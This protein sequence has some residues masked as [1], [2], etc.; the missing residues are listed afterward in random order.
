MSRTKPVFQY[1]KQGDFICS[2]QSLKEASIST[3]INIKTISGCVRGRTHVGM[4]FIW[5]FYFTEDKTK[6]VHE[7]KVKRNIVSIYN[8]KGILIKTFPSQKELSN[9]LNVADYSITHSKK[10][11]QKCKGFYVADGENSTFDIPK[12]IKNTYTFPKCNLNSIPKFKST[13]LLEDG[14]FYL[15]RHIRPDKNE[16]FYIGIGTK[17]S[18]HCGSYKHLYQRAYNKEGR[19]KIWKDILK[20]NDGQFK[21]DIL[22]E[23]NIYSVIK[24]K[25]IEFIALYG[26][27]DLG[28]GTLANLTDGGDGQSGRI[29]ILNRIRKTVYLYD[30]NLRLLETT[31]TKDISIKHGIKEKTINYYLI[32][33][34]KVRKGFIYS[35][36]PI[37]S[38]ILIE[39]EQ[40]LPGKE[41][42]QFKIKLSKEQFK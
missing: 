36:T 13:D 12:R 26:R 22:L 21:V 19:N 25:E 3:G 18:K 33:K 9:W 16:P 28:T 7:N 11:K 2:F 30:E 14:K 41:G 20:K 32:T 10:K 34:P 42:T 27:K 17:N 38:P 29:E 37:H 24:A 23:T 31:N 6:L 8:E 4:G 40:D 1:N 15:Y 35:Y 39:S 5:K